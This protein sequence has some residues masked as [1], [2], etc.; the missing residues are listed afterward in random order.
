MSVDCSNEYGAKRQ[1][2]NNIVKSKLECQSKIKIK[3]VLFNN[4]KKP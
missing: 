3:N 1:K 4:E 2:Y